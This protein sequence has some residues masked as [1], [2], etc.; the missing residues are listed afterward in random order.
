MFNNL[1]QF[2]RALSNQDFREN[3]NA[4]QLSDADRRALLVG[5]INGEQITAYCNSLVT[6]LSRDHVRNNLNEWYGITDSEEAVKILDWFENEGHRTI[7]NDILP[8]IK[9]VKGMDACNEAIYALYNERF[10]SSAAQAADDD[11]VERIKERCETDFAKATEFG[12]NLKEIMNGQRG[13]DEF[14]AFNEKNVDGGILAWDTGRFVTIA[15]CAF[16]AGYI[17]EQTAWD[18]IRKAYRLTA[19]EYSSWKEMATAYIIGRGMWGGDTM[20]LNGIYGI[21]ESCLTE[22]ESPWK[23]ITLK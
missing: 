14:V 18:Y 16:D 12:T 2:F 7:F 21:A 9:T 23:T 5:L 6:G 11:E 8:I 17:D 4:P 22:D 15:R 10:R 13:K 20:M 3:P 1:Q 19:Q